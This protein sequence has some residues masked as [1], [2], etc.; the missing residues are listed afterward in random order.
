MLSLEEVIKE[1]TCEIQLNLDTIKTMES[2]IPKRTPR[3]AQGEGR[4]NGFG[5]TVVEEDSYDLIS[6]NTPLIDMPKRKLQKQVEELEQQV[7]LI[8]SQSK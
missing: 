3:G 1:M 7:E 6:Q 4:L 5:L 8:Q 2:Q